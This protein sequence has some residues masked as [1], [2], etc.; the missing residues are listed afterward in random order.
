[1]GIRRGNRKVAPHT[2]STLPIGPAFG[3]R[4]SIGIL[5]LIH[6]QNILTNVSIGT[7]ERVEEL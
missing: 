3:S 6:S 5:G 2:L 1:V 7:L 4:R